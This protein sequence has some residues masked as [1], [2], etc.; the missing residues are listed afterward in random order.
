MVNGQ[1]ECARWIWSSRRN[2]NNPVIP[3]QWVL[4]WVF[5]KITF[6]IIVKS[7]I[8]RRPSYA[9]LISG[10]RLQRLSNIELL[11]RVWSKYHYRSLWRSPTLNQRRVVVKQRSIHNPWAIVDHNIHTANTER[12]A[13]AGILLPTISDAGHEQTEQKRDA[14]PGWLT[15]YAQ[16]K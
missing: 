6:Q 14:T 13:N 16:I 1:L 8:T 12:W 5:F 2:Q 11:S 9:G 10:H 4:S 7:V 3:K 15:P